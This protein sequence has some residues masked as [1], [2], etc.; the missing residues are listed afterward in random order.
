[1]TDLIRN[2]YSIATKFYFLN[3]CNMP[4]QYFFWSFQSLW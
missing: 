3:F 4:F 2:L 1:M